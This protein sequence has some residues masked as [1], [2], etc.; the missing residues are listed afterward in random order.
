[1]IP[2]RI[3]WISFALSLIGVMMLFAHAGISNRAT[4]GGE[5]L[6]DG[7]FNGLTGF[8]GALLDSTQ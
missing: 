6:I 2:S 5:C 7:L 1:M 3:R 4:L 8:A